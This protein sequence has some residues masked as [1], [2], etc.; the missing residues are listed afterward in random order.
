MGECLG[1]S[2]NEIGG[3]CKNL[4]WFGRNGKELMSSGRNS[5]S[6]ISRASLSALSIVL[7]VLSIP[8]IAMLPS[9]A[10]LFQPY[11]Y[12]RALQNQ[13]FYQRF[14]DLLAQS[15]LQNNTQANSSAINSQ[16]L[17]YLNQDSLS[18]I[19]ASIFTPE[20]VQTQV[21]GVIQNFWDFFNFQRNDLSLQIDMHDVKARLLGAEGTAIAHQV[22]ESWPNCTA[23]DI[24]KIMSQVLS[25]QLQG[26]PVCRPPDAVR[27]AFEQ[28]VQ[29]SLST[30]AGSMPDQID[31][32]GPLTGESAAPGT[33]PWW[34]VFQWY[35]ILRWLF[36]LT[37]VFALFTLLWMVLLTIRSLPD[38]LHGSGQPLF[39]AGLM[40]VV[41]ALVGLF[42]VNPLLAPLVGNTVP[43]LPEPFHSVLANLFLEV[44]N[45]F[46]IWCGYS[47][48]IVLFIGLVLL[49]LVR[50]FEINR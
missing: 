15:M 23:E 30:L 9:E 50:N 19:L 2:V 11:S 42:I 8:A 17:S 32:S 36:R 41:L 38:L 43:L 26:V 35:T 28:I 13:N 16:E 33:P 49:V 10:V 47:S 4:S 25:G 39:I 1:S 31:L 24:G 7:I 45:R 20:W 37:P 12:Q 14:P 18:Q 29:A 27:P 34:Q 22:V 5:L 6:S 46:S 21:D 48:M 40:G 44:G 3:G